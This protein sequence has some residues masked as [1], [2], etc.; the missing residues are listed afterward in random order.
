MM[1]AHAG[2]AT[3]E[4]E[5]GGSEI[6]DILLYCEIEVRLGYLRLCHGEEGKG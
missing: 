4:M 2:I 6:Q 3:L 1:A 5:E